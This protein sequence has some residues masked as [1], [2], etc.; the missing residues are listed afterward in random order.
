MFFTSLMI[1]VA[2]KKSIMSKTKKNHKTIYLSLKEDIINGHY[3][4]GSLLPSESFLAKKIG[5]SRP[6]V[7]KAY[8]LLQDEGFI[9]KKKGLGSQI[10]YNN[11]TTNYTIGLLLPGSGESEIFSIINDQLL[12]LSK[13]QK[14]SC[15]W[16][17]TTA[18]NAEV[19]KTLIKKTCAEY[20]NK[21]VDGIIFA[22]LERTPDNDQINLQLCNDISDANIPL[23]LID[24]DIVEPPARSKYD[25]V[26]IDN[27]NAG[28]VMTQH[29]IHSGCE[30][31]HFFYRPN[32][33][34][35]V[36]CRLSG[37]QDTVLKNN[38]Y[39]TSENVYCGKP[40]DVE[41][42]KRIKI[43]SGKTGIICANDSTA[44]VLM[45]TLDSIGV[46]ISSDILISG[47]DN[48]KYSDHL[49]F[50]LTSYE[51]PCVEIANISVELI[52]RRI[53]NKNLLP[54]KVNLNGVMKIRESSIFKSR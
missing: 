50:S 44:A 31:I 20:I 33:A 12:K 18:N 45:S 13:E 3:V 37:I 38:L 24:R 43:V 40:E 49:K 21:N 11:L 23:V 34:Y 5:V 8:N 47:F 35:S 42:V 22:P 41:F 39:F 48:M 1:F 6:T 10:L 51:Q 32:S 53:K 36:N 7:S 15:L 9:I 46:R 14:F 52:L 26:S 27:F 28:S 54:V 17:G 16:E 19:R 4:S 29:L 30:V 25:L 2:S